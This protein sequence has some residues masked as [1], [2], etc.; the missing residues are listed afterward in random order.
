MKYYD[1]EGKEISMEKFGELRRS[2][3][4][5]IIKQTTTPNGVLISTVWIGMNLDFYDAVNPTIFESMVFPSED[6]R[7]EIDMKK[8]STEENA[9]Q[10]HEHLVKKWW[11]HSNEMP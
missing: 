2:R 7:A 5:K 3:E 10:G 11:D 6:N 4:Y 9:L 8:Y 1:K